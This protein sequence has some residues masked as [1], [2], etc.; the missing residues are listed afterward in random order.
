VKKDLPKRLIKK[1]YKKF[2]WPTDEEKKWSSMT[3]TE[4][5]HFAARLST[6][7]EGHPDIKCCAI[8]V[9]KER[10]REHIRADE[11][12]LYNYMIK[13]L[14]VDEMAPH[15]AVSFFPDPRSIKVESGNSLHDY[16][17]ISLW[18]EK[19]TT[20]TLT[21]IPLESHKALNVQFADMLS[22]LVQSHYEDG[23]STAWRLCSQHIQ[24][25]KLYF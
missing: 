13:L 10:V 17:Q 11:N 15:Q 3:R 4:R 5:S 24:H 1:L 19:G 9:R 8:T 25:K 2:K 7:V 22:G 23:N 21:T 12:K 16:L 18:F 20:T 6:L 14:L